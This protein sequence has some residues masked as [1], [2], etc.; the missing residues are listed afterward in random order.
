MGLKRHALSLC[1]KYS[2]FLSYKISNFYEELIL[3]PIYYSGDNVITIII[4]FLQGLL[5]CL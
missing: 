1:N 2:M 3:K 5:H 4:A